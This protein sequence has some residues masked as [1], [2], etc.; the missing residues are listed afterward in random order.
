MRERIK[1]ILIG[2]AMFGV[3][4][5]MYRLADLMRDYEPG[6]TLIVLLTLCSVAYIRFMERIK[7]IKRR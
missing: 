1:V 6:L 3:L 7:V 5:G 2:P 4:Y